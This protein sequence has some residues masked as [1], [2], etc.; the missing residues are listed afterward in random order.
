MR[1]FIRNGLIFLFFILAV[2]QVG[3]IWFD[4][5]SISS[6]YSLFYGKSANTSVSSMDYVIHRIMVNMSDNR[7][8]GKTN[9]LYSS[10]QKKVFDK[11]I[12]EAVNSGDNADNGF[13]WVKILK[14]RAVIYEFDCE[15]DS[16][17][18][19]YIFNGAKS[20]N[21]GAIG[22]FDYVIAAI[23]A[24]STEMTVYFYNSSTEK[25]SGKTIT[26]SSVISDMYSNSTSFANED[27]T[28]YISSI[29]SGFDIFS[30]NVFIPGWLENSIEYPS[31]RA[32]GIYADESTAEKNAEDFF[33]NPVTK[34]RADENDS[35][36]FSD[37]T[38]VVKYDKKTRVFEYYN[39]KADTVDDNSFASN[40]MAAFSVVNRDSF[41]KN[42]IHLNDYDVSG[43]NYTFR[44]NYK[45]ND[46]LVAPSDEL[47]ASIGMDSFIEVTTERGR[48][49]RYRK[50]A[51]SF[52]N[53]GVSKIADR[54]FVAAID[55]IYTDKKVDNI[56]LCYMADG[57]NSIGLKWIIK[58]GDDTFVESTERE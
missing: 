27:S 28:A 49:V 44:F 17:S 52:E 42:E 46:R 11:G 50:Y 32:A 4:N 18:I 45:L 54:D 57:S 31:I 23:N 35:L 16:S 30:K 56:W 7:I 15:M 40:Y 38:T 9:D 29:Q 58:I 36:T 6:I 21:V 10:K 55:E 20:D 8:V 14:N 2:Y 1:N 47:A 33:D 5:F 13:D 19:P 34:W 26:N 43:G 12:A 39:Y 24:K 48:V 53:T 22:S 25:Y 41:I 37:E 51:Y 3:D